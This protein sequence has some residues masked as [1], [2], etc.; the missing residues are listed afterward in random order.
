MTDAT[1]EDVTEEGE[2]WGFYKP[3]DTDI[4]IFISFNSTVAKKIN[5]LPY[6]QMLRVKVTIKNPTD[7]GLPHG[8]E[9]TAL[10]EMEDFLDEY[11]E[12]QP[13]I[14]AGR[15]TTDGCRYFYYYGIFEENIVDQFLKNLAEKFSYHIEYALK[16]DA[17][18]TSYWN[19]LYP[20][21]EEWQLV[22]N[23]MVLKGIVEHGDE[24]IAPRRIDHWIYFNDQ[25]HLYNFSLWAESNGFEI[26][27]IRAE[28]EKE[29]EDEVEVLPHKFTLQ[30][31]HTAI[32]QSGFIDQTTITLFRKAKEYEG[33]YD[34]WETLVVSDKS[35]SDE[36]L[37]VS[38]TYDSRQQK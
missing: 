29:A 5:E 22:S 35:A 17:E 38:F 30:I 12:R 16:E 33:D 21:Q 8:E 7:N 11:I 3:I 4:P 28:N 15:V 13:S 6:N 1:K 34:G 14:K 10:N 24:L 37:K 2:A 36:P 19:I 26:E 9:F 32:P 27:P 18:K 31:F 25:A 20:T 23:Q